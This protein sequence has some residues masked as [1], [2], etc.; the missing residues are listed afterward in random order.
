MKD[1]A[2]AN[3]YFLFLVLEKIVIKQISSIAGTDFDE[4]QKYIDSHLLNN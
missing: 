2:N 3:I 1:L 4:S